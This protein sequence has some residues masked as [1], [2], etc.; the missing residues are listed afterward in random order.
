MKVNG[1]RLEFVPPMTVEDLIQG[2]DRRPERVAVILNGEIVPRSEY[3]GTFL[4]EEDS[5]IIVGFVGGG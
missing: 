4:N 5:V 2:S 3:S 1:E